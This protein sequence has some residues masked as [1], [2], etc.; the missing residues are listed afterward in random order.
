M[1]VL[2]T[3]IFLFLLSV[4]VF[5]QKTIIDSATNK[6]PIA[7]GELGAASSLNVKGG[8]SNFGY[9]AAVEIT[10]IEDWL[11]LELGV[12]PTFGSH[13]RETDVD[14]LFKKP[15]TFSPKLEFMLGAGVAWAHTNDHNVITNTANGEIALDFM[16]WPSVKH[17]FGWY[18]EPAFDYGFNQ[19]HEQSVGI[20][21][22][23]L[24]AIP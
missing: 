7:V 10:P 22:G 6:E 20:S 19:E 3:L 12:T 16:F 4:N 9:S 21:A 11:E 23:L 15:W 1:K 8:K 2:F 13:L 18:L 14:F 5:A 24:I 17:Q